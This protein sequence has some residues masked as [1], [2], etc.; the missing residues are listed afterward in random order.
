MNP[1]WKKPSSVQ[2]NENGEMLTW[3]LDETTDNAIFSEEEFKKSL[4]LSG[5]VENDIIVVHCSII[6]IG[7]IKN[8][9]INEIQDNNR[10]YSQCS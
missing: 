8:K 10:Y 2:V 7:L 6:R 3:Y 4:N 5:I 9:E 1:T